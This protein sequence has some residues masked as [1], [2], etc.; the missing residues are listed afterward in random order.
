MT[1]LAF[2][3][4]IGILVVAHEFGHFLAARLCRMQVDEFALGMGPRLLILGRQKET[5]FTLRA[6]PLGGFVRISGME[7]PEHPLPPANHF[8]GRPLYQ[9]ALTVLAGPLFS[10]LLGYFVFITLGMTAGIATDRPI[11]RVASVSPGSEAQRMGL[12]P[13]DLIAE[14]DGVSVENGNQMMKLI[15]ERPNK[16]IRVL[17]YRGN[18]EEV[19]FGTPRPEED[20]VTVNG[21][22]QTVTIGRFGF[23]PDSEMERL[24]P[25]ESFRRG[26]QITLHMMQAIGGMFS[27][28]SM[29]DLRDNVGGPVAIITL[30][31]QA[32]Q[33]GLGALL[34][35]TGS[36]SISL[37]IFNLLPVPILDGG[38]LLLFFVEWIRRG[39]RLSLRA[40]Q[41]VQGV[42]LALLL[43][44]L[45]L[46]TA[47][48]ILRLI[49]NGLPR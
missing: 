2:L 8:Y 15:R 41:M 33:Q 37:G 32:A 1:I 40:L 29:R 26:N 48:D 13:G 14:I 28:G 36:L 7:E 39:K 47:N 5:L 4:I 19:L 3:V 31:G 34:G 6:F 27:K 18:R 17:V 49:T 20:T 23:R 44:L 38:H 9:R 21:K 30:S 42:G 11:N 43:M 35:L 10:L 25:V 16:R 46:V 45:L 22:K 24:G 12:R